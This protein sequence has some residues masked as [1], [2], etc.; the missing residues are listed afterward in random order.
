MVEKARELRKNSTLSE[1]LLWKEIKNKKLLGLK[2]LRQR[3]IGKYILDFY[4]KEKNI[5]I[6][7]DGESHYGKRE[8]DNKRDEYLNKLGIKVIRVLDLDVKR[9]IE[10]V[11]DYLISEIKKVI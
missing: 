8:R 9:N 2:F 3:P 4:C 7:I 1:V 6:E 11:I 5:C 10:G